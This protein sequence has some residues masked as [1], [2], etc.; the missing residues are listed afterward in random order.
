[1]R[2]AGKAVLEI[3]TGDRVRLASGA[4]ARVR[5]WF[6][7]RNQKILD[8]PDERVAELVFEDGRTAEMSERYMRMATKLKD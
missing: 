8:T 7:R 1:M 2:D 5:R 3:W 4:V 6:V